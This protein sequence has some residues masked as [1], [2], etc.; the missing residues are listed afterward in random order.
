ML[1]KLK[2][3]DHPQWK[4]EV[5]ALA[6]TVQPEFSSQDERIISD[7]KGYYT[8]LY[9]PEDTQKARKRT[10]KL[11][12]QVDLLAA[13]FPSIITDDL[14]QKLQDILEKMNTERV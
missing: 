5:L 2:R 13:E 3:Y 7:A 8:N 11:L 1:T 9:G 14:H 4:A 12:L 10:I 6:T